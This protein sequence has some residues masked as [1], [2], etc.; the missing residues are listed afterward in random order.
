MIEFHLHIGTISLENSLAGVA[1]TTNCDPVI[2][3]I[4]IISSC[5]GGSDGQ[6]SQASCGYTEGWDIGGSWHR[7]WTRGWGSFD[8]QDG[9]RKECCNRGEVHFQGWLTGTVLDWRY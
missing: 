3:Q 1:S 8:G 2:E 9:G 4:A 7:Q 6:S 5:I